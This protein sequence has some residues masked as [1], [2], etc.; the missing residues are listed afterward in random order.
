MI[1]SSLKVN[2]MA[3]VEKKEAM[4][5]KAEHV[6]LKKQVKKE[7]VMEL[8]NMFIGCAIAFLNTG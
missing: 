5:E 4:M 6:P 1:I 2:K 3:E 8:M 7:E